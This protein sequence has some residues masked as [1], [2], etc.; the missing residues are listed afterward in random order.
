[1]NEYYTIFIINKNNKNIYFFCFSY[2]WINS[3]I[4][5]LIFIFNI[6]KK[7][8]NQKFINKLKYTKYL[9]SKNINKFILD[10]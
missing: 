8:F 5:N 1:M 9:Q 6:E 2:L 7:L 10:I 3:L 4:Q